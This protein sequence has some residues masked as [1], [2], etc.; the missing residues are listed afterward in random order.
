MNTK[1]ELPTNEQAER[2]S[3]QF[4]QAVWEAMADLLERQPK[5]RADLILR[6]LGIATLSSPVRVA[7]MQYVKSAV[8]ADP[9]VT[10]FDQPS[11]EDL[12]HIIA[13]AEHYGGDWYHSRV[14]LRY[15]GSWT[16][17]EQEVSELDEESGVFVEFHYPDTPAFHECFSGTE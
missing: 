12:R 17:L 13:K 8:E 14:T 5:M 15:S 9:L 1:I 10:S 11:V 4:E 7:V 16:P 6:D 3:E 2:F